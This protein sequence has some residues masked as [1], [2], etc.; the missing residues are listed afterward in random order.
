MSLYLLVVSYIAMAWA[1]F[2][3]G[4]AFQAL[5]PA[6]AHLAVQAF[7]SHPEWNYTTFLDIAFLVLAV[8]LGWRFLTTGGL[9]M[10]GMMEAP[11]EANAAPAHGHHDHS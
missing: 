10:L 2:V 9:D 11:P 8:V 4:L 3:I 7:Q 6:P 1:G 5:G